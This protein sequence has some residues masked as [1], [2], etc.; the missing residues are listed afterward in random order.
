M[1]QPVDQL[2]G[3]FSAFFSV[4]QDVWAGFLAGWP[5]LPGNWHHDNW[6]SRLKF[7]I[8]LFSK[9]PNSLRI[10][11]IWYS[12]LYTFEYGPNTLFRSLLPF[13]FGFGPESHKWAAPPA[14]VGDEAAKVEAREMIKLFKPSAVNPAKLSIQQSASKKLDIISDS[15]VEEQGEFIPAPFNQ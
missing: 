14:V 4:E 11:I 7:C 10:G 12:I 5:G 9:M 8:D 6:P 2:R 13:I 15:N 3:F 1:I